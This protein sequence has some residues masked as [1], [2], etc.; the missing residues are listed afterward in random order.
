MPQP[1]PPP[2]C[3]FLYASRAS[4]APP[5]GPAETPLL[6][7]LLCAQPHRTPREGSS[8]SS[9]PPR[10]WIIPA[11]MA[12]AISCQMGAAVSCFGTARTWPCAPRGSKFWGSCG[13]PHLSLIIL[14]VFIKIGPALRICK[15]FL[16]DHFA[17]GGGGGDPL[18]PGCGGAF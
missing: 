17:G 7:S 15:P 5:P 11:S 13:P 14:Q 2:P 9:G 18:Q 8:R 6:S 3:T 10:G 12:S 16:P 4:P 1:R